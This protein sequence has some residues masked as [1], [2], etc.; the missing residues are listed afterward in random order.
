[1]EEKIC[2]FCNNTFKS[3]SHLK[4][5]QETVKYCLKIQ[6]ERKNKSKKF[7]CIGCKKEYTT[8]QNL[9]IHLGSCKNI[10]DKN[11]SDKEKIITDLQNLL[12]QKDDLLQ[13]NADTLK[14]NEKIITELR[15]KIEIYEKDHEFI[16]EI[17]KQPKTQNN[18]INNNNK[19]MMLSPFTMTQK[20]IATIVNNNFT[21]EHFL[22]G[23]KGV[24][25]FTSTNLLK[26]AEGK[27][28]YICT[29][30]SRNVFNYKNKDGKVEKDIKAK[31]LT[32]TLSPAVITKSEKLFNQYKTNDTTLEYM[33]KL[34]DIKKLSVDNDRF[35]NHLSVLASNV[36]TNS[37]A[38]KN[39]DDDIDEDIENIVEEYTE[40][41]VRMMETM[42]AKKE[43]ALKKIESLKTHDNKRLYHYHVRMFLEKYGEIEV[44]I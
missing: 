33:Q 44:E 30:S 22:D 42:N 16:K 20:D 15:A 3:T 10:K 23:Q 12:Q 17:A 8:N 14:D 11:N 2:N 34:S 9:K 24:A 26:D 18:T 28:T 43:A 40:E 29:D 41:E 4:K 21:K 36:S 32:E 5:H 1:M 39:D 31:K 37:L 13:Q 35:V 7:I 6:E 38:L 19:V 27:P 25:D